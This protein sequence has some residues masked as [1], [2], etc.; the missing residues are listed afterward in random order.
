[1]KT[2]PARNLIRR[3]AWAMS[4]IIESL[5]PVS[6]FKA[7]RRNCSRQNLA[8]WSNM[9]EKMM[10]TWQGVDDREVSRRI[11]TKSI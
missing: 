11:V 3:R 2:A 4:C 6:S 5:A 1:M 10:P 9:V 8:N 7:Q